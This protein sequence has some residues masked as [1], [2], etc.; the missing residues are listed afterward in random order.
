MQFDCRAAEVQKMEEGRLTPV[1]KELL[2][3]D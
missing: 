3:S 1:E 2:A